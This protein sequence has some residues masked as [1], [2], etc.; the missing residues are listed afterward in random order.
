MAKNVSIL[1]LLALLFGGFIGYLIGFSAGNTTSSVTPEANLNKGVELKFAMR[2]LWADHVIWTRQ[3]IVNTY[4]EN[5]E[6]GEAAAKLFKNQEEIGAA[7]VPYYGKGAGD[8]LTSL[9]K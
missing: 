8:K 1:I 3:Y 4:S 7:I 2:K 5:S 9:L 6:S